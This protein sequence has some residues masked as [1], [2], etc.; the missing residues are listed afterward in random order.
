MTQSF[1]RIDELT[2]MAPRRIVIY[3]HDTYGLGHLRRNIALAEALVRINRSVRVIIMTG[4]RVASSFNT[5]RGIELVELPPVIKV[6]PDEYESYGVSIPLSLIKRARAAIIK[7]IV[8]RFNPDIFYVDHSPLG[9]SKELLGV[10]DFLVLAHPKIHRVIGLRDVIDSPTNLGQSWATDGVLDAIARYYHAVF[11]FGE[12]AIYDLRKNYSIPESVKLRYL[13]YLGKPEFIEAGVCRA[14]FFANASSD[15][16]YFLVTGGGG[17]DAQ[18]VCEVGIEVGKVIQVPTLVV[19]G[20]LMEVDALAHLRRLIGDAANISL[21][22]F[23]LNIEVLLSKS[24]VALSMAGYNTTVELAAARVPALY[25]P[26]IYPRQ[27]QLIRAKIFE[28]LGFGRVVD[29]SRWKIERISQEVMHF[30]S[31]PILSSQISVNMSAIPKFASQIVVPDLVDFD[32]ACDSAE[33]TP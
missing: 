14:E 9:M 8:V 19:A 22:D 18:E 17:G 30:W 4:S 25:L 31:E 28:K 12:E 29:L 6:G 13:S 24:R 32:R 15:Q 33:T 7:D 26:R 27:E 20:P 23:E 21:I 16:G 10:L 5:S 2:D 3:S 11:V 1:T